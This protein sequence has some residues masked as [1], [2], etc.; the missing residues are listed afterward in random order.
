[1][2]QC[3]HCHISFSTSE[4]LCPLCQNPLEGDCKD[5]VFPSN[6]R[7]KTN[8]FLLRLFLF[9]SAVVF[10]I[11]SFIEL[12]ISNRIYYSLFI[13]AGLGTNFV[14]V[15]Y[16]LFNKQD[17]L[18]LFGKYGVVLIT[19]ALFW[20][21]ITRNTI[22]TNYIIPSFCIFELLFNV[23]SF[24][25][26]RN[27]YIVRYL[28][29]ILFNLFLLII[30]AILLLLGWITVPIVSL[31][32]FVLGLIILMGLLIFYFDD[33]WLELKKIFNI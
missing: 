29:L 8:H 12:L 31:I 32:S 15:T 7:Q 23:I 17:I 10:V 21:G 6:I 27:H 26:L 18:D 14:L 30:P 1:M 4:N 3:H 24:I 19:L 25:A 5:L 11:A 13:L 33:I 2:K 20:Y 16:V 9:I 22:I 28:K